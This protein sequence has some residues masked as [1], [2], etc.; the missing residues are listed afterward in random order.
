MFTGKNTKLTLSL[1]EIK[2][3]IACVGVKVNQ[4][5]GLNFVLFFFF[6]CQRSYFIFGVFVIIKRNQF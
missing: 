3:R 2:K 5:E 4:I 6:K 1:M